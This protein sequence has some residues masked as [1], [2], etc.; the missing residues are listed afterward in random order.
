MVEIF[1]TRAELL[2]ADESLEDHRRWRQE[3]SD[4]VE[5]DKSNKDRTTGGLFRGCF[6]GTRHLRAIRD[7][8]D[9]VDR[10][11]ICSWELDGGHCD[12]CN[13]SFGE[14]GRMIVSMDSFD[15]GFSDLEGEGSA[16]MSSEEVDDYELQMELDMELDME[17]FEMDP[18]YSPMGDYLEDEADEAPSL[19]LHR[20][21]TSYISS[22]A[23]DTNLSE[24][25]EA[26]AVD[27]AS[28]DEEGTESMLDSIDD[29]ED[30]EDDDGNELVSPR[31][32][33]P[34]RDIA[35]A[36]LQAGVRQM[37]GSRPRSDVHDHPRQQSA[38]DSERREDEYDE[39][40]AVSSGRRRRQPRP[41]SPRRRQARRQVLTVSNSA[42]PEAEERGIDEQNRALLR[43]GWSPLQQDAPEELESHDESLVV[44]NFPANRPISNAR[45]RGRTS[46]GGSVTPTAEHQSHMEAPSGNG[47]SNG[48]SGRA[49]RALNQGRSA[50]RT[51]ARSYADG[52][53]DEGEDSVVE[54]VMSDEESDVDMD[55]SMEQSGVSRHPQATFGG[56]FQPI[57]TSNRGT[58]LGDVIDIDTDSTSDVSVRLAQERRQQRDRGQSY[59]P[60]ISMMFARHQIELR[61][62][63]RQ[64]QQHTP[65]GLE[66]LS[67]LARTRTSTQDA[68]LPRSP[69][70]ANRT[71]ATHGGGMSSHPPGPLVESSAMGSP[72]HPWSNSSSMRVVRSSQS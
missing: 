8:A 40:G 41:S 34:R 16:S 19:P 68:F 58:S 69:R 51:H 31:V 37:N 55:E 4:Y 43:N 72:T 66:G 56:I 53:T 29:D 48:R 12:G 63:N 13:L 38:A 9:G 11:P 57:R 2:S 39:G 32:A 35:L 18:F 27:E 21:R 15:G 33:R 44:E 59:D 25:D 36:S 26:A 65:L 5:R 3:E 10:C 7:G 42:T 60:W 64:Q 1:T 20:R 24:T 17:R 23:S 70:A 45:A 49:T 47:R 61:E 28:D 67:R 22:E 14:D 71:R 62:Y 6:V 46:Q 54:G 52:Y 50:A 30:E